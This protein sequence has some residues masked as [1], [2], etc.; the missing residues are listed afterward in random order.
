MPPAA[1]EDLWQTIKRGEPWTGIVKNRRKNGDHYWVGANVTPEIRNGEIVGYTS[2]RI[3][4]TRQQIEAAEALY[5]GMREGT[6][7]VKV[8]NGLVLHGGVRGWVS[9]FRTMRLRH[10]IRL[11]LLPMLP[12]IGV[13][14]WALGLG[15]TGIGALLLVQTAALLLAC[16]L[17]EAQIARPLESLMKRGLQVVSGQNRTTG[18][19]DRNDEIGMFDRTISQLGLMFRWLIDDV[20]EQVRTVQQ[21]CQEVRGGNHEINARAEAAASSVGSTAAA[22]TRMAATIHGNANIAR[23]ATQIASATSDSA[24]DGGRAMSEVVSTMHAISDGSKRIA[25]ITSLIEE[26][27]FQTNILA[28]NAAVEAARAGEQGRGFAVVAD[29]VRNLAQRSATAAKE[30]KALI[31]TSVGQVATGTNLVDQTSA[32]MDQI[33]NRVKGVSSMISDISTAT[34]EQVTGI[35]Q[36][37]GEIDCLHEVTQKSAMLAERSTAALNELDQQVERLVEALNVLR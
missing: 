37:N 28:L 36:M 25:N 27:A 2:V 18:P 23:D 21:T 34:K 29:E 6:I 4:P 26:I 11:S 17:L 19:L 20:S 14:A 32:T 31:D 16:V 35:A 33:V 9:L 15:W 7:R 30:I 3:K 8:H 12:A 1:F 10:R 24:V 5:K 13:G 22:M